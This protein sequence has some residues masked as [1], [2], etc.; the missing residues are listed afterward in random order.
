MATDRHSFVAFY[1]SDWLGGTARM[2]RMHRSIYFDICCYTWDKAEPCPA[3]ELPLMLGDIEGWGLMLE[4]L[5]ENGKLIRNPDGSVHNPKALEEGVK[6]FDLWSRKSQG[7]KR[8]ADKTNKPTRARS[9]ARTGDAESPADTPDGTPEANDPK[10]RESRR[11]SPKSPDAEPEPELEPEDNIQSSTGD[12]CAPA[13]EPDR[14]DKPDLIDLLTACTSAAGFNPVSPGHIDKQVAIV[15]Q[16][17]KLGVDFETVVLPTIRRAVA[18]SSDPTTSL[19]RF[20]KQVR[21]NHARQ[22]GSARGTTSARSIE[23]IYSVDGEDERMFHFR[24]ALAKEMGI[25]LYTTLANE[26]VRFEVVEDRNAIRIEGPGRVTLNDGMNAA[27]LARAAK[28]TGF[29]EVW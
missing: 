3:S 27:S 13:R 10:K 11:E 6:A 7:G 12:S 15:Q 9:R 23:P 20:D 21:H 5:I 26:R 1:P 14:L 8:G 22:Q 4:A 2:T 16:W 28:A 19:Q 29:T 25:G 18:E 24:Q 17:Q